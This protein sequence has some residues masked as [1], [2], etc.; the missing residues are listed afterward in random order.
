MDLKTK[1]LNL[2]DT[3][4]KKNPL[5]DVEI[6]K[7]LDTT[8]ENITNIRKE[9]KIGNSR[10]R[11]SPYLKSALLALKKERPSSAIAELTRLLT[12]QGFNISRKVIEEVLPLLENEPL[13]E[14]SSLDEAFR[15]PFQNLIGSKGSLKNAIEQAKSAILYPPKGLPSLIVGE[16]GVGKSLFSK[17]MYEFARENQIV[18][19]QAQF[20]VFNCAD[21]GDNPQLLLS[22]L[23][24]YKKGAF[25]GADTDTP[26][27]VEQADGGVLFLDEIHR[28]PPKG[29]EILFSIL[30]RGK[31][32]RLGE[33]NTERK[34]ELLL[35]GATTE[36][37]EL[38]LL[39]TFRRRIPMVIHLPSL[40]D[41]FLN[42]RIELIYTIFQQECNRINAK[43]FIDKNVV[44]IL[45]LN[46]FKGNIGQLKNMIQVL[47]AHSFMHF[48]QKNTDKA[49][50]LVSIEITEILKLT[51][52]FQD[53]AFGEFEYSELRKQLRNMVLIP[54]DSNQVILKN[55]Y[56]PAVYQPSKD[57][58]KGIENKYNELKNLDLSEQEIENIV[59]TFILNRFHEFTAPSEDEAN[60]FSFN[61][62]KSFVRTDLLQLIKE[63]MEALSEQRPNAKIHFG[64]F[65]YLA[66]H[67]EEAIKKLRLNQRILNVNV[68]KIQGEFP[69]EYEC[70]RRFAEKI[71]QSQQIKIPEDEIAFIALYLKAALYNET[72]KNRVGLIIASHGHIASETVKVIRELLG[73]KLP[74]A[75]DMPLNEKPI[76]I[77][78]KAVA[79]AKAVHQGKGVL[80]L[81]DMGSLTNIG[82]IVA[83]R[84]GIKTKLL[85]RVN[86][87]TALEATRKVSIGEESMDEIYFSLRKE[88]MKYGYIAETDTTKQNAILTICLTGEGNAK[89]IS[90]E[91]EKRYPDMHCYAM[92]AFDENLNDKI[93]ELK[94]TH[95][96]LAIVG[97]INPQ[98][99]GL[100]F[101]P[102]DRD[103]LKNLHLYLSMQYTNKSAALLDD[104]L[105]LYEPE[106]YEKQALL[107]YL[108][109]LLLNKGY[110]QKGYFSSVLHREE[111]LPTFAKGNTA[112]PHGTSA[113]VLKTTFV[114][115]KLQHP[116]DWGVGNVNFLM[117]PVFTSD[118]KEIVK[119]MMKILNDEDFMK[120]VRACTQ[121]EAFRHLIREK[122][123]QL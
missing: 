43:I 116:I 58:Y 120:A 27:L 98:I 17:T 49:E 10:Q 66:I 70:S 97:T 111:L 31:F 13:K 35:I 25:T 57:I 94:L 85:D 87:L 14:T 59:W 29:Q 107:E 88:H 102:Y 3:E 80:F 90:S 113:E 109:S 61:E 11:R 64:A 7:Y 56:G 23:F 60:A 1:L 52:Q 20:V 69:E 112:V 123:K 62:L 81:V 34:V 41:W 95:N 19:E 5:T 47:C 15:D 30:D 92:S 38:N 42:E 100:N 89:Y 74:V 121:A 12:E 22:L 103:V 6:A 40:K 9:L 24:G 4:N 78:N 50:K 46:E 26:G 55:D 77:Y 105:I 37:L 75:L 117:M 2:V 32:R 21:Y 101:I 118:D 39:L 73:T 86:L 72:K 33:S 63:W 106:F 48:L 67:L 91:I 93:A 71:E 45:A 53:A 99:A 51:D 115:V 8:R 68:H 96:I 114:F 44:E 82:N 104:D 36:N 119:E 110:V 79:L 108:G 84:T 16:S 28:L 18:S 83:E 65:K 54:F 76:N 122:V